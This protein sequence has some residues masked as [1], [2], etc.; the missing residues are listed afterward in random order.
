MKHTLRFLILFAGILLVSAF[1]ISCTSTPHGSNQFEKFSSTFLKETDKVEK[2]IITFSEHVKELSA[3]ENKIGALSD[4]DYDKVGKLS[5][6]IS[7]A[8]TKTEIQIR[9]VKETAKSVTS[10]GYYTA[11]KEKV[12]G[13]DAASYTNLH[14]EITM[15]GLDKQY[16]DSLSEYKNI[17]LKLLEK[18]NKP[19]NS[20]A[21][22]IMT[23]VKIYIDSA[24]SDISAKN[25][26]AGKDNVDHANTALKDAIKLDL[27]NIEQYKIG[28]LQN[29]LKDV[30]NKISLGSAVK[31]TGSVLK[32]V[33]E[34]AANIWGGV[35]NIIKGVGNSFVEEE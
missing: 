19:F 2:S 25:W 8:K 32:T 13:W 15:N 22:K 20:D 3:Y 12:G 6:K 28:L 1:T 34:G 31:E 26:N 11:T 18:P 9:T 16:S 24:R 33:A 14:I 35:G 17:N 10:D 7:D 27:N 29:D 21:I 30:A 5:T 4:S 23:E